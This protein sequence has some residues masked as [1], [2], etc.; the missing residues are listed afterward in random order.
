MDELIQTCDCHNDGTRVLL[1]TEDAGHTNVNHDDAV[2]RRIHHK[3]PG[4]WNSVPALIGVD[5]V[6][7]ISSTAESWFRQVN[8]GGGVWCSLNCYRRATNLET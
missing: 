1:T 6:R 2:L 7:G 3:C 5:K 4:I 8:G